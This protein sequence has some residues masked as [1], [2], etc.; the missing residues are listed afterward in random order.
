[1]IEA[2][3]CIW[4]LHFCLKIDRMHNVAPA[5]S[6]NTV[7]SQ[8]LQKR[9]NEPF[10]VMFIMCVLYLL[11]LLG[12]ILNFDVVPFTLVECIYIWGEVLR[13]T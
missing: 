3:C 11:N 4:I 1:M 5:F 8:E 10:G 2:T 7:G 6:V 9:A 12:L 13:G